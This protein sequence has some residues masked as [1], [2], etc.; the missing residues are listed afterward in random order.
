MTF[1]SPDFLGNDSRGPGD[2]DLA[3]TIRAHKH[4]SAQYAPNHVKVDKSEHP[5][6]GA[7]ASELTINTSA[8]ALKPGE[9][10]SKGRSPSPRSLG[11]VTPDVAHGSLSQLQDVPKARRSNVLSFF[12][13]GSADTG[14]VPSVR[15]SPPRSPTSGMA[16]PTPQRAFS[17]TTAEFLQRPLISEE[18]RNRISIEVQAEMRTN[19]N[20]N[21]EESSL[22]LDSQTT[23]RLSSSGT[24]A[25]LSSEHPIVDVELLDDNQE[26]AKKLNMNLDASA[27]QDRPHSFESSYSVTKSDRD[28]SRDVEHSGTGLRRFSGALPKMLAPPTGPP[29]SPPEGATDSDNQD[30]TYSRKIASSS[31][32]S[33]T[34]GLN[35][36]QTGFALVRFGSK[37]RSS[38]PPPPRPPPES[39]LPPTPATQI[40]N[41]PVEPEAPETNVKKPLPVLSSF[42]HRRSGSMGNP[43]SRKKMFSPPPPILAPPLG[44]LPPT[45]ETAPPDRVSSFKERLR[46]NSDPSTRSSSYQHPP[47]QMMHPFGMPLSATDGGFL[48]D[49]FL[50]SPVLHEGPLETDTDMP[51]PRTLPQRIQLPQPSG[52]EMASPDPSPVGSEPMPL[53][54]PPRRSRRSIGATRDPARIGSTHADNYF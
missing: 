40:S 53:S 2:I 29:P 12:R 16:S 49:P 46:M 36:R 30:H 38:V 25:M 39:A 9:S 1:E 4:S 27:P 54:P 24:D 19:A 5:T 31:S 17:Q 22:K 47:S 50:Y 37:S 32:N 34:P 43:S 20:K 14:A 28:Y 7:L 23:P 21:S 6:K 45:P 26:D 41:P 15:L 3:L 51:W 18:E 33:G 10:A 11:G 8:S 42:R 48:S 35:G 13:S 44:P 52:P